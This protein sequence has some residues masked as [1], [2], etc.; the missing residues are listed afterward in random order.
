M[1]ILLIHPDSITLN[2]TQERFLSRLREVLPEYEDRAELKLWASRLGCR[3]DAGEL[4]EGLIELYDE[5]GW[6]ELTSHEAASV[7]F[8]PR[9]TAR[10]YRALEQPHCPGAITVL[11]L[12]KLDPDHIEHIHPEL[13]D[14]LRA[15]YEGRLASADFAEVVERLEELA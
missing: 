8:D 11:V 4:L 5:I 14:A 3:S 13:E 2:P 12:S 7:V 10:W 1:S 6:C 9:E 15:N